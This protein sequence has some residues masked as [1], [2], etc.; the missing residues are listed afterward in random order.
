MK[1]KNRV[2]VVVG[3]FQVPEIHEGHKYLLDRAR[4][5]CSKLLILVGSTGGFSSSN[6]PLDFSTRKAMLED[7]Y[8]G[9]TI[10]EIHDNP[11]NESWS[12]KV[13]AIVEEFFPSHFATLFG[14][15]DSFLPFYSGK[16]TKKYV[17]PKAKVPSGTELRK[18]VLE[19]VPNSVEFRTGIIYA[20]TKQNFPTSFQAVDIGILNEE[21]DMVLIGRKANQKKWRFIG[22]FVDPSDPSL[23]VAA[24]R[25]V[26]EEAG[27]IE[28]ADVKYLASVR[29][30]DHRYRKSEHKV[31]T[32]LFS[33][34]YIF[35]HIKAGDD[36]VEVRWEKLE[37]LRDCLIDGHLPLAD[38][39]LASCK[40]N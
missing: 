16:H 37:T 9:S 25:E 21:E 22:G 8:P 27:D 1:N 13:D 26:R 15:R 33:A 31:M 17:C 6:D 36:L 24:K 35:G 14:S 38:I 2:G 29:I 3:R 19:K 23:E 30:N 32:A 7:I 11:S 12:E 4:V 10:V 28:V 20:G 18:S 5:H 39:F 34:K 40:H